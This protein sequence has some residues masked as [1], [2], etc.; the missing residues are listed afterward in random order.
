[1]S[2]WFKGAALMLAASV[3]V[4]AGVALARSRSRNGAR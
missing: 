3:L 2:T 1:M 4:A